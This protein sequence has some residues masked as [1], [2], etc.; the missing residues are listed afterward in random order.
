MEKEKL[1]LSAWRR[2]FD[3]LGIGSFLAD[4]ITHSVSR[5]ICPPKKEIHEKAKKILNDALE[6]LDAY[7]DFSGYIKILSTIEDIYLTVEEGKVNGEVNSWDLSPE[8]FIVNIHFWL[9]ILRNKSFGTKLTFSNTKSIHLSPIPNNSIEWIIENRSE[10]LEELETKFLT[11]VET[12]N[13][14]EILQNGSL[15]I[16]SN[17]D[18]WSTQPITLY[19]FQKFLGILPENSATVVGRRVLTF[20]KFKFDPEQLIRGQGHVLIT[21]P[22]TKNGRHKAFDREE[23]KKRNDAY[24]EEFKGFLASPGNIITSAPGGTRDRST[25]IKEGRVLHPVKPVPK[26]LDLLQESQSD[27]TIIPVAFHHG[28]GFRLET[29]REKINLKINWGEPILQGSALSGEEIWNRVLEIVPNPKSAQHS[30][31]VAQ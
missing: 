9:Q 15:S 29:M 11:W 5:I 1:E 7:V 14:R 6:E 8:N 22:A 17:H 18:Q 20:R 31:N 23:V 21:D 2:N 10:N 12:Y 13:I 25:K 28:E 24:K 30:D 27:T 19:F 26:A 16:I 4:E 3:T